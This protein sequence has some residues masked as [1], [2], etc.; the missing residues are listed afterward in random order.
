MDLG[1]HVPAFAEASVDGPVLVKVTVVAA[2]LYCLC[3]KVYIE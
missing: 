3:C 2:V 1:E